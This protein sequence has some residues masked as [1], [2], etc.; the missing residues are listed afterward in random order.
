[1][2]KA[3]TVITPI[4]GR[5]IE[6]ITHNMYLHPEIRPKTNPFEPII[7]EANTELEST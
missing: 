6:Q 3:T 1:M 7:F 2:K 5:E 4:L